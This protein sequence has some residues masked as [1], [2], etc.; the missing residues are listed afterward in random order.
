MAN[1]IALKTRIYY[2]TGGSVTRTHNITF[3][4]NS[5]QLL[6]PSTISQD[7]VGTTMTGAC[8]T[9]LVINGDSKQE[10]TNV[11]LE[12]KWVNYD[13]GA[14]YGQKSGA[15]SVDLSGS[16]VNFGFTPSNQ[17]P[18]LCLGVRVTG[19]NLRRW[20]VTSDAGV[21]SVY[22]PNL[23]VAP[24]N[25]TWQVNVTLNPDYAID[26]I[27]YH[28]SST[29]PETEIS[30]GDTVG[31]IPNEDPFLD[32]TTTKSTYDLTLTATSLGSN[33]CAE[34]QSIVRPD[35]VSG[36]GSLAGGVG[37]VAIINEAGSVSESGTFDVG[38]TGVF[39]CGADVW[40][41]L[42]SLVINGNDY[43]TNP[44][45]GSLV[46]S[47]AFTSPG[48]SSGGVF[49][50]ADGTA[51]NAT[52]TFAED[53]F[54][55]S[56]NPVLPG[57]GSGVDGSNPVYPPGTDTTDPLNPQWPNYPG[58]DDFNPEDTFGPVPTIGGGG[59]TG[60]GTE[61]WIGTTSGGEEGGGNGGDG[62]TGHAVSF[63]PG[64][65]WSTDAQGLILRWRD[66]NKKWTKEH[67]VGLVGRKELYHWLRP[68]GQFSTRQYE[69]THVDN[70]PAVIVY[71]EA[72]VEV[73]E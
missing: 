9:A 59:G 64:I 68:S 66:D 45:G 24:V 36:G 72:D 65:D 55:Y 29:V 31:P 42:V 28:T 2:G 5:W 22:P 17:Q 14:E 51:I 4:M 52:A 56:G 67:Y 57:G 12:F 7:P 40:T 61:T 34:R 30:N 50:R 70:V 21:A 11:A 54:C 8:V 15:F 46:D 16:I 3:S 23:T 49:F 19:Y 43:V 35:V 25:S 48:A 1:F 26:K 27:I 32:V 58:H 13:T 53:R 20:S 18:K 63:P 47:F 73:I 41:R 44:Y 6:I 71:L 39:A 62:N 69:V 33:G 10:G 37:L 38:L 60:G